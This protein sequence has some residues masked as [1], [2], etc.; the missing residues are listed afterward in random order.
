[1]CL[2]EKDEKKLN[3][4]N[5]EIAN[6]LI[7]NINKSSL[8][9][10]LP[11]NLGFSSNSSPNIRRIKSLNNINPYFDNSIVDDHSCSMKSQMIFC[12]TI[13]LKMKV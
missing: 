7:N 3:I 8:I 6:S 11:F 12:L 13:C 10:S 1:M 2:T 9:L 4:A 5:G